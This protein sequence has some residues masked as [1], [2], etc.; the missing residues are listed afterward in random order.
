MTLKHY[1]ALSVV[2]FI[3]VVAFVHHLGVP[4]LPFVVV[5]LAG[6]TLLGFEAEDRK[7]PRLLQALFTG[8]KNTAAR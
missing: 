2:V 8:P 4:I 5:L 6:E 3:L 1:F 7:V